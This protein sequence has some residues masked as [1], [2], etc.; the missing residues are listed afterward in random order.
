MCTIYVISDILDMAGVIDEKAKFLDRLNDE[1]KGD[2]L[3]KRVRLD[4]LLKT[5]SFKFDFQQNIFIW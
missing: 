2:D 1:E 5:K 4:F 3:K